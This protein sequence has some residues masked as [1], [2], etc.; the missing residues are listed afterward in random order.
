MKMVSEEMCGFLEEGAWIRKMFEKGL[1]LKKTYGEDAVC[2]F[3]LGNPDLP[4][5]REVAE[6]LR[7]LADKAE[8]P[9][10]FGYMPN[11]G[12]PHVREAV[13][14][15]LSDEQGVSLAASDVQMTC[16]A[17]GGLN[18]FFRAVLD[19][20]EEVLCPAPY[21][22]DY[23]RY[24]GNH[25]GRLV[26]VPAKELTFELDVAA[27]EAAIT[28][29]TRAVLINSPNNPTGQIYSKDEIAALAAVLEEKNKG[30][31]RP[32]YLVA[33]EPYRFLA[34]DGA[35][36]PPLLPAYPFSVLA[37]SFSK[38]LSLAGAR[39]GYVALSP[40]MPGREEL[41]SGMTFANRMLG[42][43]NAPTIGQALLTRALGRQVDISV[44]ER[45][46]RLMG[47]ILKGAGYEFT[48]P[49]GAF[50]FFPKAPGGDDA[51]FVDRLA[52][53]RVLG[54]PGKGFGMPGYFRLAFCVGED[55]IARSEEGF[56]KAAAK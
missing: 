40:D 41:M 7:D 26:P 1:E 46:R 6:G 52:E 43:I 30:R 13:A 49:K 3:S 9:F 39:I 33:D 45:R 18:I 34:F 42:F 12:H 35:E 31:E 10:T 24:V 36:V 11:P 25:G 21:F 55:V 16:G 50:Y 54:V 22:I 37:S 32:I 4:A 2:D 51:A 28:D 20:G 47:D 19:P 17:A 53:E 38:N 27:M 29:K 14:E 56:R 48:M 44:Y 23:G 8:E 5:P 15:Y